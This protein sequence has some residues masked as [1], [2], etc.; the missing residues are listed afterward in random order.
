MSFPLARALVCAELECS[1]VF[2]AAAYR[3]C[4]ACSSAASYPVGKFLTRRAGPDHEARMLAELDRL[5][6]TS[7]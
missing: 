2:D 3:A 5:G 4:P 1:T 7:A 6:L